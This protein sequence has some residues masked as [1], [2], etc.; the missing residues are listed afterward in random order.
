MRSTLL[1]LAGLLCSVLPSCNIAPTI[2]HRADGTTVA[3]MGGNVLGRL[4]GMAASITLPNGSHIDY[5]V[6]DQDN[7]AVASNHIGY[8]AVANLANNLTSRLKSA[9]GVKAITEKGKADALVKGTKDP[10]IIPVDPNKI[11]V[12]P[13]VP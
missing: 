6:D 3:T 13:N 7:S 5:K 12:D 10:N 2:I 11:P 1:L 8:K 4:K 9:D